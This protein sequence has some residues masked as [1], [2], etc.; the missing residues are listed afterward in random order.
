VN[1]WFLRVLCTL[2]LG[3]SLVVIVTSPGMFSTPGVWRP[4]TVGI[5]IGAGAFLAGYI[6]L[7]RKG[8]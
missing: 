4:L 7:V 3:F 8:K 1:I 2:L 6:L 5:T